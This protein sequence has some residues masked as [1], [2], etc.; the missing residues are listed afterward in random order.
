LLKQDSEA[1]ITADAA[2]HR[3]R[4]RLIAAAGIFFQGG[5]ATV[6]TGTII[7]ALVHGL[8]G[9]SAVA[10]GAAAAIVRSGWLIPQLVIGHLAQ[11]RRERMP[12]YKI[13]AFGRVVCLTGLAGLVAMAGD[14]PDAGVI[15][16][17]FVLWTVYAF[18]SGIVAV[19]Y[20]DIVARLIVSERRS[21]VLAAR[22]F[23]GGLLA[24]AVAG[25]ADRLLGALPF[26][27]SFAAVLV[28]GATLLGADRVRPA[29][30]LSPN[31]VASP[32]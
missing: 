14:R 15:A 29:R 17:F 24:L 5:A 25:A 10:V 1:A 27:Q 2:V 4:F 19:P 6:D 18:V 12:L 23:G 13:G 16:A 22:F 28:L 26:P 8:T 7:P 9:G 21:R 30:Y 3:R 20:N 31:S 32:P 11:R